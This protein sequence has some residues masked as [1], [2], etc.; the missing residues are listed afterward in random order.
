M[1]TQT[2]RAGLALSL[3]L[4]IAADGQAQRSDEVLYAPLPRSDARAQLSPDLWNVEPIAMPR[5][6]TRQANPGRTNRPVSFQT[7]R[8]EVSSGEAITEPYS[9]QEHHMRLFNE[10]FGP[11]DV[12][13]LGSYGA[14]EGYEPP[15]SPTG[16][17]FNYVFGA[18]DRSRVNTT[19]AFPYR[20]TCKLFMRFPNGRNYVGSGVLVGAKYVLTAGHC[21][22]NRDYGGWATRIEVVPGLNNTYKPYGS[23]LGVRFRAFADWT[24]GQDWD[25][26]MALITLDRSVGN[27]TGW[28]PY[29]Y[30]G[31]EG[32]HGQSLGYPGEKLPG[33]G[34]GMYYVAGT[35]ERAGSWPF[36][37]D[38][39]IDISK[40]DV[41]PGQS[42]SG[43]Y[44]TINGTRYVVGV[45]SHEWSAAIVKGNRATRVSSGKRDLLN[46]WIASGN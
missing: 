28:L 27:S 30:T 18:D 22:Y 11:I 4:G 39:Q 40:M 15:V 5:T 42:G 44:I 20:T 16:P 36:Y 21:V 32:K 7:V 43:V 34:L 19:T 3:L 25:A 2:L 45:V 35:L 41:T 37:N 24:S 8:Y 46:Q 10:R 13:S 33:P 6:P 29:A 31:F 12:G 26:D 1:N 17:S 14:A 23:A 38:Y 9:P